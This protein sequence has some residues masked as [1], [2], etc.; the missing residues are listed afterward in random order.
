MPRRSTSSLTRTLTGPHIFTS[1]DP[2]PE[3]NPNPNPNQ[4]LNLKSTTGGDTGQGL[5]SEPYRLWTL[6]VYDYELDSPMALYGGVPL[7]RVRVR[8]RVRARA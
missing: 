8:V 2:N 3:P 4:A 7:V 6:D 5:H 1:A